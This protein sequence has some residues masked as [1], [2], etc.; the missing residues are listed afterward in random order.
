[1]IEWAKASYSSPSL[2]FNPLVLS[3]DSD[4]DDKTTARDLE[5]K[6]GSQV[7][8]AQA[9]AKPPGKSSMSQSFFS[10][11]LL[12]NLGAESVSAIPLCKEA[13][14]KILDLCE[15]HGMEFEMSTFGHQADEI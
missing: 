15:R 6:K 5:I 11:D 9:N 13:G 3:P 2:Q 4:Y 10:A 14:E 7:I 12:R 8:V 1:M